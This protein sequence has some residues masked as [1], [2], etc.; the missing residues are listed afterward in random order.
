MSRSKP[1]PEPKTKPKSRRKPRPRAI[2]PNADE[3]T[4]FVGRHDSAVR[5]RGVERR[6]A[7]W[8][9]L[10]VGAGPSGRIF[11][12]LQAHFVIV[13]PGWED[14]EFDADGRVKLNHSGRV[15]ALSPREVVL[16]AKAFFFGLKLRE[17]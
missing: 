11:A 5:R 1:K 16:A 14:A 10:G 9:F 12:D 13:A 4:I 7:E 6:K 2:D 17:D 3:H 15:T 8:Y